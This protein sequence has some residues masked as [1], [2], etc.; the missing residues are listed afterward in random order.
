[1]Y[2]PPFLYSCV[3]GQLGY[4]HILVIVGST[5]VQT[6]MLSL[7]DPISIHLDKNPVVGLSDLCFFMFIR[8]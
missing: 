6:G 4:F 3:D 7:G 2:V 1:M 5:A 8:F